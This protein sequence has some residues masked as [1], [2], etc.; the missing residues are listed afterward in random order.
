MPFIFF[1]SS[2]AVFGSALQAVNKFF[3]PAIT[4]AFMNVVYVVSLVLCMASDL[5]VTYFCYSIIGAG[6]IQ[7]IAHIVTYLKL[8]FS[9]SRVTKETWNIFK[10]IFINVFLCIICVGMT[11]EISLI[12]DTMFASYLPAGSIS[13]LKYATR[14]MGIPL[15]MFASAVSTIT[16]PTFLA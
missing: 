3:I 2:S 11:S 4:P 6:V 13:L 16:L 12:V 1:I 5:P 15:G 10:P 9:F 8:D 14:F 7:L